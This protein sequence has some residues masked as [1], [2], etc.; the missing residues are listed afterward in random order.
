MNSKHLKKILGTGLQLLLLL[1]FSSQPLW[2]DEQ[3]NEIETVRQNIKMLLP[4]VDTDSI[5]PAPLPGL[6]EVVSGAEVVYVSA[7]GRYLILGSI[8]DLETRQNL[9]KPRVAQIRAAVIEEVGEANMVIY[10]PKDAKY[11][12]T[13][14]T[15]IDCGYC[16]KL[17]AEM[18]GYNEAGIRIRYLFYPRAGLGSASFSKAVSVWCAEDRNQAM[19]LAKE[20]KAVEE[21]ECENPVADHYELGQ[22]IGV[23]GT[24]ALV[25]EDGD[26]L[27]GYVP[28]DRLIAYLEERAAAAK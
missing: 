1:C 20:G 16:R 17:H 4:G 7:D 21:K 14:F 5:R 26:L 28:P 6:Y 11:T 23:S 2:A 22:R 10:G 25:L 9:T 19:T 13:V 24:P 3:N 15:D 18:Q 12:V 8:V 27:P